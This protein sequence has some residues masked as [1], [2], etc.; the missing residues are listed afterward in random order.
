MSSTRVDHD[1]SSF[2]F[3]R[4]TTFDEREKTFA[5]LRATAP[6]S[7]HRPLES[8]LLEPE[9]GA[10]DFWSIN[11]HELI[12]KASRDTKTF[13]SAGGIFMEDFP[14]VVVQGSLSFIVTDAPRHKE[15]RGI[16]WSAF[17][18]GN[19]R[20]L[21]ED[22]YRQAKELVDEI[23]PLGEADLATTL[24]KQ[25]PGRLFTNL[26]G[27][28]EGDLRDEVMQCAEDM[29]SWS[30]EEMR[31]GK[32]AIEL[33]GDAAFRL[34][35]IALDLV[36]ERRENPQ[37]DLLTWVCQ[38][39][40]EDGKLE[41]WEVGSFFSLLS[42]AA[43]DT[44][45]HTMAHTFW[46]FDRFP[47]Q[48]KLWQERMHDAGAGELCAEEAVRWATPLM[49]FRR[50]VA[51][52]TEFGGVEMQAGDKVALWYCS[53]NRDETV[54]ERPMEFDITRD[55]N[56]HLGFGG[57]GPHYCMGAALARLTL[58][59]ILKEVYTRMPDLRIVGE[60]R[61]LDAN[62][63]HGVKELRAEWTPER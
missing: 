7:K 59:S 29:A 11:T 45:R 24:C 16:V 56:R 49:H 22:I 46:A 15:L 44:T 12:Q 48:R 31:E 63:V 55:P 21:E 33:F 60:P 34:N 51:T 54:F 62:V 25:L 42:A 61:F 28:P 2:E 18:P 19:M 53:G 3:W 10:R 58:R 38:A 8:H 20:K 37:D 23:A 50:T 27:V 14:D 47:E 32:E 41:D 1:I 43:N 13:S 39:Q 5:Q 52:D 9:D 35:D 17:T 36:A 30:D 57:G 4:D 40:T 6:V 26:F